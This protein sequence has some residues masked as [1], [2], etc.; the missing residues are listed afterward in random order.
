VSESGNVN[1]TGIPTFYSNR[2]D[3]G[4]IPISNW[5]G[6]TVSNVGDSGLTLTDIYDTQGNVPVNYNFSFLAIA[7]ASVDDSKYDFDI[8]LYDVF[9][10]G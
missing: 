2:N 6:S 9:V 8:L 5:N 1:D 4:D 3:D 7:T 10:S